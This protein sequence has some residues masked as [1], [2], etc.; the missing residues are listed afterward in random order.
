V[1]K[2]SGKNYFFSEIRVNVPSMRGFGFK[3]RNFGG[4]SLGHEPQKPFFAAEA[5]AAA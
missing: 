2:N 3:S 1:S 4:F 5:K